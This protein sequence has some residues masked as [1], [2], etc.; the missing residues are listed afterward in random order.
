M[1][2]WQL[3]LHVVEME[4]WVR[5]LQRDCGLMF[6]FLKLVFSFFFFLYLYFDTVHVSIEKKGNMEPILFMLQHLLTF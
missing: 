4:P 3:P 6:L 1:V 5:A 2:S